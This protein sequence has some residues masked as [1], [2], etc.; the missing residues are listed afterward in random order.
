MPTLW[1]KGFCCKEELL[2]RLG[3]LFHSPLLVW[4]PHRHHTLPLG[5]GQ[6]LHHCWDCKWR[7]AWP[8]VRDTSSL[9][10]PRGCSQLP[11]Q[12]CHQ[13]WSD[14]AGTLSATSDGCHCGLLWSC[15]SCCPGHRAAGSN[16]DDTTSLIPAA[17]IQH[18][19]SPW[20][21]PFTPQ[22][23]PALWLLT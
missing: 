17:A 3:L 20:G 4:F 9:F 16:C 2:Q 7:R 8:V 6:D 21:C 10:K 11:S 18:S 22:H 5:A 1:H 12:C 23:P 19:P 15:T 13:A 14:P